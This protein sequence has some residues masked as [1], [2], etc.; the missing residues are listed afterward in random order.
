MAYSCITQYYTSFCFFSPNIYAC[1][2]ILSKKKQIP[3]INLLSPHPTH[4]FCFSPYH[5]QVSSTCIIYEL[6]IFCLPLRLRAPG[7][8]GFLLVLCRL[9]PQCLDQTLG[10]TGY[11]TNV[12][13]R[14]KWINH[15]TSFLPSHGEAGTLFPTV[16]GDRVFPKEG[17]PWPVTQLVVFGL[18]LG[19]KYL[20]PDLSQP[21]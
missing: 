16:Q 9:C 15:L 19:T 5:F 20:T 4:C 10:H 2:H 12:C 8:G 18:E 14:N 6:F 7:R 17:G 1:E 13:R 11:L 21:N 3:K